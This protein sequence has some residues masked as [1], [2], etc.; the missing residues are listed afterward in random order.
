MKS[1]FKSSLKAQ[2]CIRGP[3]RACTT[4]FHLKSSRQA[5]LG[6]KYLVMPLTA[7]WWSLTVNSI[8]VKNINGQHGDLPFILPRS[9]VITVIWQ[10]EHTLLNCDFIRTSPGPFGELRETHRYIFWRVSSSLRLCC[11]RIWVLSSLGSFAVKQEKERGLRGSSTYHCPGLEEE[12]KVFKSSYFWSVPSQ[13]FCGK[14]LHN[15]L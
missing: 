2:L 15:P 3:T 14:C 5:Y 6:F 12:S 4:E 8:S 11:L 10:S 13:I 1:V 7:G 9:P